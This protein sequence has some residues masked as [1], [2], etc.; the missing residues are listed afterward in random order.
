MPTL[1]DDTPQQAPGRPV[2]VCYLL[3][4]LRMGG[5]ETKLL[6]LIDNLDRSKVEPH[7]C[8][9]DG[10]NDTSR[11]MEPTTCPV[12]RLAVRS[13]HHPSTPLKLLSFA[14]TLYKWRIDILQVHFPDSTYF[15]VLAG[16]IARVP[17][18]VRTRFNLFYWTT[19]LE[20]TV[21]RRIDGLYNRF[22]VDVMLTDCRANAEAALAS[23]RYPPRAIAVIDNGIDPARFA[24]VCGGQPFGR[25]NGSA[26]VGAVAMLRPVK[27]FDVLVEAAGLLAHDHPDVSYEIA[28][29]GPVRPELERRLGE[30]GLRD[31]FHLPGVVRDVGAFLARLDIAVLCS[32]SE[33][34]SNSLA[35]YMMAG[36]AIVAT[37]VPGNVE[38]I[39]DG[40]HGLL[41]PANDPPSLARAVERLLCD[42]ELAAR[43]GAAAQ[44]RAR[45]R[46]GLDTMMRRYHEFYADLL[47]D[48]ADTGLRT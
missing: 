13:L 7:L 2:R 22:F 3:D 25:V 14:R 26:R 20:R 38:M 31:R 39:E 35:E 36:R 45:E 9:L 12:R 8:L 24:A 43:L 28:G 16:A 40:V 1:T 23:E 44:Q 17:R 46:F 29:D 21:G 6:R 10:E 4:S 48:G 41:V 34:G 15:G 30:L 37:A 19:R 47:R 27:R 33:G 5:T 32:E 11:S 42:P 18:I